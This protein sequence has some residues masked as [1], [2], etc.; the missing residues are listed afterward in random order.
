VVPS[1]P[2]R[3]LIAFD[4]FKGA[5]SAEQ[6]GQ[7]VA[8]V[9]RRERPEWSLD[10]APLSDGGDGFARILT[11]AARGSRLPVEA[12]GPCFDGVGEEHLTGHMG[13]VELARL[14]PAAAARVLPGAAP[15]AR[16]AVIDMASINGLWQVP[17]SRRD[18]WRASSQGT[19]ELL[20]AAA[21]TGAAAI[22][23]GVGGSATSDLGLGALFALGLRFEDEA[24]YALCPPLPL[25]W[26]R[27]QRV[28]GRIEGSFPPI[29]I[30]T[31]VDNPVFGPR[32]AAAIYGPQKG[33]LP[34]DLPRFEAEA[35][36]MALLLC[37]ALGVDLSLV[38]RAGAGAAGGIAFG[39]TA[40]LGAR[41]ISGFELVYDWLDLDSRLGRADWIV[42]GEGRFDLSSL[43]GKGP[44]A[45]R[46][47]AIRAGKRCVTFAG[48]VAPEVLQADGEPREVQP[49]LAISPP[50]LPLE[51]ALADS[52][53]YLTQAVHRW[54]ESL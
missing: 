43:S 14:P 42:T 25:E 12:R 36:R 32:G 9:L 21:R 50:D 15:G 52:E 33:L 30:A 4:K 31:D 44:G 22:V 38:D 2:Q 7:I 5:L 34:E 19:G 28:R 24:G 6:A 45:L 35:R 1:A 47:R 10:Q 17:A 49:V 54:L 11:E 23:L 40:A 13:L 8:R 3:V 53:R 26:P 46:A 39:L 18:V 20:L 16:L 29:V 27:V 48:A 37:T 41:L 51:K